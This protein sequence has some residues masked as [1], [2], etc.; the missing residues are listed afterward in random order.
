MPTNILLQYDFE[1]YS[2]LLW[3]YHNLLNQYSC[4]AFQSLPFFFLQCCDEYSRLIYWC[5]ISNYILIFLEAVLQGQTKHT[6]IKFYSRSSTELLKLNFIYCK[7]NIRTVIMN[8]L[9]EISSTNSLLLHI[10]WF[11]LLMFPSHM[12]RGVLHDCVYTY[13]RLL[14]FPGIILT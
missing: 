12:Q 3:I 13:V 1:L 9:K 2:I 11:Y 8:S 7:S 5:I 6:H 4:L 14:R 10:S